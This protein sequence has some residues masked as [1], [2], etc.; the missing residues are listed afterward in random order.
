METQR[1]ELPFRVI[2]G[3][4][5]AQY[6]HYLFGIILNNENNKNFIY[7]N[8]MGMLVKHF[9]DSHGD[10]SFD[11]I[12]SCHKNVLNQL[13]IRGPL[14]NFHETIQKCLFNARYVVINL[15]EQNLLHR[16]VYNNHY[17]RHDLLI[18][19]Y[20]EVKQNY[21]TVG[22]DEN[23][24]FKSIKYS[25]KEVEY[26][27]FTMENEWDFEFF[28]FQWNQEY[29][30]DL[31]L[32]RIIAELQYYVQG[33]NSNKI[34]LDSFLE[35]DYDTYFVQN[36][37]K[38]YYG[39]RVYNYLQERLKGQHKLFQKKSSNEMIGVN[40]LRTFNALRAHNLLVKNMLQ[41]V[42]KKENT[43]EIIEGFKKHNQILYAGKLLLL[44]Y[45]DT[46]ERKICKKLI[47]MLD[48][49]KN[50]EKKLIDETIVALENELK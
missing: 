27:Y 42:S 19:G 48:K 24:E 9:Y 3:N 41:D 28:A 4:M 18:Y 21:L 2:E 30:E 5:G 14:E 8:Y 34:A 6:H 37:Y 40:D 23:M 29:L 11:G 1:I 35:G 36:S 50:L 10:F 46:P 31:N 17:F 44:R 32:P 47:D 45:V 49:A 26:A 12:Y 15:N 16:Q 25:F 20:D 39:I 38:N 43:M 7:N 33:L 22:F 13:V